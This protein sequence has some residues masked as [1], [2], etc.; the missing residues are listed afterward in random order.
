M[1][2]LNVVNVT[3][4]S[5]LIFGG[6]GSLASPIQLVNLDQVNSVTL[7]YASNPTIGQGGNVTLAPLASMSFD[8]TVSVWGVAAPGV[9][10]QIGRAHV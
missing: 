6:Q 7:S 5:T 1:G 10:L 8:G 9:T 3:G 4:K 2:N